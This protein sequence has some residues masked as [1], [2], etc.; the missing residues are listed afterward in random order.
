MAA[1]VSLVGAAV[2]LLLSGAKAHNG[3]TSHSL[4]YFRTSISQPGQGLPQFFIVGYLDDQ[5]FYQY[6]SNSRKAQPRV[7]WMEK[8]GE[9]YWDTETQFM[10]DREAVSRAY[11]ANLRNHYNQSEEFHTL[12]KMFGCELRKDGSTG[13]FAKYAYD[14]T[15]HIIL[16]KETLTWTAA[17]GSA[18]ISKKEWEN[19]RTPAQ[20]CKA[21]LKEECIKRLEKFL[22]YGKEALLRTEPPVGK[23]T[24]QATGGG[25]EALICQ[26]YGFYPKEIE[27]TW[28]KGEEILE[29]E[30]FRRN[31]AP[32][33]DGTYHIWLSI[34]IDP[35]ERNFYQCHVDHAS[36]QKPLVLTFEEPGVN[37]GLIIVAIFG[38]VAAFLLAA[39]ITTFF[40]KIRHEKED[41]KAA[42]TSSD[43]SSD[44]SILEKVPA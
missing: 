36:L 2:A 44:S 39:G 42:S 25:Q 10:R 26:A 4:R 31:I 19:I 21:Y 18:Q 7:T 29:H 38:V 30:T 41:Y 43:K 11:M 23:I 33:Y 12:Q 37:V 22:N 5:L 3:S 34:D 1:I 8:A 17:D 28:R 35:K 27:A 15:D 9:H 6:D 40:L 32:N 24:S 13:G 20:T 14:G 16:D